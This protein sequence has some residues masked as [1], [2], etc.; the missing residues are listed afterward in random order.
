MG[1][2]VF[3]KCSPPMSL[4][5][6]PLARHAA[7]ELPPRTPRPD[8]PAAA[9]ISGAPRVPLSSPS[10]L[11]SRGTPNPNP[12]TP[13]RRSAA[14]HHRHG[15]RRARPSRSKPMTPPS[16]PLRADPPRARNRPGR[17]AIA[18][19]VPV[20]SRAGRRRSRTIA[21]PPPFPVSA[22]LACTL[23]VSHSP[24]RPLPLPSLPL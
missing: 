24:S 8:P 22:E 20:F 13:V 12:S 4:Q 23:R 15:R 17:V 19:A 9:S 2:G 1:Q 7:V 6:L 10:S 3:A 21:S 16:P 18:A 5:C 14:A 11:P